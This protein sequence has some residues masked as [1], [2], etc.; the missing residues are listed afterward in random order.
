MYLYQFEPK[1]NISFG[2]KIHK[3]YKSDDIK[4]RNAIRNSMEQQW[5]SAYA[6]SRQIGAMS[7]A[8]IESRIKKYCSREICPNT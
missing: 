2:K 6:Y 7:K 4:A 3:D 1:K 8:E 5:D